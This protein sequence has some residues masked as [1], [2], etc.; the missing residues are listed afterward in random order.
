MLVC[1]L[2]A[3]LD[4]PVKVW[5]NFTKPWGITV[6]SEGD[7]LTERRGDVVVLS[8]DGARL[9]TIKTS[10]YQ[11]VYLQG[12]TVDRN[13]YIYFVDSCTSRIF[14]SDRN[15]SNVQLQ[16]VQQVDSPGHYDIAV[17]EMK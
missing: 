1:S 10:E 16:R 9:G 6:N 13:D 3:L 4:K 7:V 5:N 17:F 8:K 15:C 2:P 14:E 11:F 12:L